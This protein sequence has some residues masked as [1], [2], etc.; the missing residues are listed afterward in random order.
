MVLEETA[1]GCIFGAG[2]ETVLITRTVIW[3]RV[4]FALSYKVSCQEPNVRKW[5]YIDSS[6]ILTHEGTFLKMGCIEMSGTDQT[7]QEI[8]AFQDLIE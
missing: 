7:L 4:S 2:L 6:W 5:H 1:R 8:P 3:P